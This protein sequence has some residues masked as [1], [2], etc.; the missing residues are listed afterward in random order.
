GRAEADP[1]LPVR[2]AQRQPRAA[3]RP[4]RRADGL[5]LPERAADEGADAEGV[6]RELRLGDER[7]RAE[8]RRGGPAGHDAVAVAGR[9]GV[10]RPEGHG[11]AG[12]PAAG[13]QE[14]L[15][16]GRQRRR[17]CARLLP[18][19]RPGGHG[20]A[21]G[22]PTMTAEKWNE[23]GRVWEEDHG[24]LD[25]EQVARCERADVAE[26]LSPVPTRMISNGEYMPVPQT[27]QQKRVEARLAELADEASRKLGISRRQFLAGS[28]GMAAAL[29]AMNDVFGGFFNVSPTELYEPAAYAQAAPPKDLFVFDDQL[30]F[31]RG[32]QPSPAA[33]RAIAQGPSSAPRV[34]SNPYNS[35]GQRDERGDTWGV[36]NP[37]L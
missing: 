22:G 7:A 28:G 30:H 20:I 36:W 12:V 6:R 21:A 35:R 18:A 24:L 17:A 11:R 31:V 26:P 37:A 5:V 2:R 23:S 16:P 10:H 1:R 29:L 32:S 15:A 13:R 25:A 19:S 3:G 33:L 9:A 27:D 34:K 4:V 8:V 14:E